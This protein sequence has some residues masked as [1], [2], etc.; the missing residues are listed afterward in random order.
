MLV[1]YALRDVL[2]ETE[3]AFVRKSLETGFTVNK[4]EQDSN[5]LVIDISEEIDRSTIEKSLKTLVYIASTIG[6]KTLFEHRPELRISEDPMPELIKSGDV[7]Q[8]ATGLFMFQG[9]FLKLLNYLNFHLREIALHK[10]DAVE[11]EY[12]VLWPI[13]LFKKLNYFKEFPQQ[14]ILT[15]AVKNTYNDKEAFA[16]QYDGVN[17]YDVVELNENLDDCKYGLQPA[18]CNTCYYALSGRNSMRILFI[19]PIIRC[20]AMN[21][22]A[23][24]V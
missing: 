21:P 12:P 7:K 20:F 1:R 18:V 19:Q 22:H 16:K 13:D 23:R 5:D 2:S 3:L 4:I 10:F 9:Q 17:D 11:Q 24:T 8:V 6:K 14:A 15:T